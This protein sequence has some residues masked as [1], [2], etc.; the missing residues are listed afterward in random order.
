M[1]MQRASNV[2]C[3]VPY[4][5]SDSAFGE[6]SEPSYPSSL[7]GLSGQ[8]QGYTYRTQSWCALIVINSLGKSQKSISQMYAAVKS[9][10]DWA[11]NLS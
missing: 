10:C 5:L 1:N 3:L 8:R 7:T 6:M 4:K 9:S 11:R 2:T